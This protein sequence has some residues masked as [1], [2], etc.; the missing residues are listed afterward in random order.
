M[1]R[2]G[3]DLGGC[4]VTLLSGGKLRLDGGAMFGI[5]PKALWSKST[6]A[7]DVNRIQLACNCLLVE[8]A[9]PHTRRV[10]IETGHGPKF[11]D[12][13]QRI[14]EIAA[15]GWLLHT[16]RERSIDPQTIT[17]VVLSHLHFDHAGGLTQYLDGR[18]APTFP[19]AKVHAQRLEWDDA[20]ANFGI[21]TNTYR[22]E[23]FTAI[24]EAGAW[25]L[26]EGAQV[27]IPAPA[28]GWPEIRALPTP[29][30][31][32]GHQS[33]VISGRDRTLVFSG[34]VMPTR[35]HVGRPYN[36][37]YDVYPIDNRASKHALLS[38]AAREKWLVAIDHEPDTPL[39]NVFSDKDW[40]RLEPAAEA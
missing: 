24:D 12:K 22:E 39:V 13:E 17:D 30:H 9:G 32:R 10:I 27:V 4:T 25:R 11:G 26:I 8:W 15:G 7:D 33:L 31:T 18:L 38:Q 20:R 28:P 35:A 23:N 21:M 19:N 1:I 37:A 34:D 36:M 6:P 2:H 16:C 40:F 5:I 14:Y 3:L 29:G